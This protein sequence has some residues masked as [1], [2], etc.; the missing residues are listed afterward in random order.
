MVEHPLTDTGRAGIVHLDG[1]EKRRVR[2]EDEQ[3]A[4]GSKS[5][6]EHVGVAGVGSGD[7]ESGDDSRRDGLSR[8]SLRIQ[9]HSSKEEHHSEQSR[10]LGNRAGSERLD[11]G[12]MAGNERVTEPSYAE[13]ADNGNHTGLEDAGVS[14]LTELDLAKNGDQSADEKHQAHDG[15]I[16]G[17]HDGLDETD[18]RRNS[19]CIQNHAENTDQED[20][21]RALG[22][23]SK[24]LFCG[25]LRSLH[26]SLSKTILINGV[27]VEIHV[28]DHGHH[29]GG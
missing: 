6:N 17:N 28:R 22:K 12:G 4:N 7:A 23:R 14:N 27:A 25:R 29:E 8:S 18:S 11:F 21:D 13:N 10:I 24:L 5:S 16:T 3:S 1:T 2:R 9:E 19:G 15:G 20:G 26:E